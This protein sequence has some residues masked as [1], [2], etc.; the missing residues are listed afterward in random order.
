MS[1]SGTSAFGSRELEKGAKALADWA[2]SHAKDLK[3]LAQRRDADGPMIDRALEIV[4][5]FIVE[6]G[7][8]LF[9][10]LAIDYALRLK[11]S[12]LYPDDERPDF[13]VL[14]PRSVDDAY[15]LADILR[16]AGFEGVGAVRGVHVQTM[17][18]STNLVWVADIGYAPRDV[19]DRIPTLELRGVRLVH[20]TYQRMDMHLA[21]CF[22]F[23]GPPRED[24]F[25]R[26]AKDLDR[27]NR[28]GQY[29]PIQPAAPDTD[30]KT[31][32]VRAETP[33][34]CEAGH[35]AE[36]L[37][38]LHGFAAYAVLR[39]QLVELAASPAFKGIYV[40]REDIPRL[41]LS[42]PDNH[43]LELE[44]PAAVSALVH[45]ASFDPEAVVG[46]AAGAARWFEPYMDVCP[47]SV[48]VD[49]LSVRSTRGRL[50]AA[51]VVSARVGKNKEELSEPKQRW[52]AF[53]VSPQY[54]L[55]HFL[56]EA[57][58]ADGAA[59]D[60]YTSYYLH[61]LAILREA[62]GVYSA[63]I[64][65]LA[66]D[67]AAQ[68]ALTEDYAASPF[69]PTVQTFGRVNTNAAYI[70]KMASR[71]EKLRD[72]PPESLHLDP[73][74]SDLLKGLPANYYTGK[75]RPTFDYSQS[76]LFHRSGEPRE[77]KS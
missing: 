13:D 1:R 57:H 24:V 62:E 37:L 3:V 10:G 20:P 14:S 61:T 35:A 26:W 33:V 70:I 51:S 55:L 54:L 4:R 28:F 32:R 23:S 58:R 53:V 64:G 67:L 38:A 63:R 22:P 31:V 77:S 41:G 16:A 15:D 12:S 27:F 46:S 40:D 60:I 19:F 50:L 47:E 52:Q 25:H 36:L 43:S 7:L 21:F 48:Q 49:A 34:V 65:E 2:D 8:I 11:G 74:I 17:R 56:Y 59:R 29:Y 18:V 66:D 68:R 39:E 44:V 69:A 76:P 73:N 72:T 5:K 30:R 9:G 45:V 6:R 42:F 75:P 71:A